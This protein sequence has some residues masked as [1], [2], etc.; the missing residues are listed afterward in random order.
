MCVIKVRSLTRFKEQS[1]TCKLGNK[2]SLNF[3]A[4]CSRLTKIWR[5]N[6]SYTHSFW[7]RGFRFA[8]LKRFHI[9]PYH[10]ISLPMMKSVSAE[11]VGPSPLGMWDRPISFTAI[12]TSVPKPEASSRE[13]KDHQ[14]RA[15][16]SPA[17]WIEWAVRIGK[18]TLHPQAFQEGQKYNIFTQ[19]ISGNHLLFS[20]QMF[21]H[22]VRWNLVTLFCLQLPSRVAGR[23]QK[24]LPYLPAARQK[25]SITESVEISQQG[26]GNQS[27]LQARFQKDKTINQI[28]SVEQALV[29]HHWKRI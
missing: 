9:L 13:L 15:A 2:G 11:L 12:L 21:H 28:K 27:K 1:P 8:G 29:Y 7:I 25:Q 20:I 14:W 17:G 4:E 22:S 16:V 5:V 19:K 6:F 24:H 18:Q 10:C 23:A 3:A 26:K